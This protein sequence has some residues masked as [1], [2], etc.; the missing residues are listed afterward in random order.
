M[1]KS[2]IAVL[3]A[4]LVGLFCGCSNS[5]QAVLNRKPAGK[6]LIVCYSESANQNTM[7]AAKWI[8]QQTG[9]DLCA[10]R[11]A[12]PYSDSYRKVL[13]ES[14]QHLWTTR[15][16]PEILPLGRNVADYDIIFVGSPVWYGTFA[17][18]LGTF[19]SQNDLSGKTVVPFC[20]HGG[21][22]AGHLFE[23]V[24][25]AVPNSKVLPG[26]TL[27]GSNVVERTLGRGTAAKASPDEVV[28]WLNKIF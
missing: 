25:A 19:F 9:G 1:K 23:D 16:K 5:P 28:N 26:L 24:A 18:P 7:T 21:G 6:I 3:A 11:M 27:K 17:P 10:V 12:V 15:I 22:G 4:S 14:K 2:A 20:T 8:Q 13:K